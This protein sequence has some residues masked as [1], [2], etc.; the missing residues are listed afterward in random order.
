[1]AVTANT[2]ETYG[3]TTIR[4][5]LSEAMTSITPT[6]CPFQTA[7]GTSTAKNTYFEWA[8]TDLADPDTSNRVIEGDAAPGVDA[9]TNAVR[10]ANYTQISDKIVTVSDTANKVNG[11]A[12]AQTTAKQIA[13][14]LKEIKR[15][16]EAMLCQNV[17]A[18]AGSSGVARGT[19]GIGAFLKTNT[20]RGA[21]ATEPTLSGTTAGYPDAAAGDGTLRAL[22][23]SLLQGVIAKCWDEG[24]EPSIV[25]CGSA[26][27]QKISSTFTGVSTAYRADTEKK[28]T[29][30]IDFYISDFGELQIVP[31]R[32]TPTKDL[33]V[34]D[35]NY[36]SVA[37]LQTMTQKPLARTGHAELRMIACEYGLKID[38]EKAHGIVA[39]IDPSL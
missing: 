23:E 28:L 10:L 3:V 36:A 31:S 16:I 7:I 17:A 29:S 32:F 35:P 13:Y 39:D 15:D 30:A 11:V 18:A 37:Y 22:T 1:M 33:Y 9:P 27:K 4:E 38:S 2:Q 19:A 20:D 12:N 34:L 5:D 21:T 24:A 14:K 6:E 26:V 25:L 8:E